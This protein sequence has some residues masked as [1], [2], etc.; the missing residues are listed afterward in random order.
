MKCPDSDVRS[1][2]KTLNGRPGGATRTVHDV[3]VMHKSKLCSLIIDCKTDD[4]ETAAKFWSAALGRGITKMEGNYASIGMRKSEPVVEVQRVTHP[5]RVHIDI[6]SDDVEAEVK[7]LEALGAKRVE[8]IR[9]WVVMEAPTGQ[10]FC[11]VQPQRGEL[12]EN[13]NV[14]T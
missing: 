13:A 8:A 11:V 4:L 3:C 6:E 5:S 1:V 10:R 12:D 9:T 2:I 7:R 14:W